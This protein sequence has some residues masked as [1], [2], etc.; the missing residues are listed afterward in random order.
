MVILTLLYS[1]TAMAQE[2]VLDEIFKSGNTTK[3]I[4][5]LLEGFDDYL[6]SLNQR[7]SFFSAGITA[8]TSLFSF[9]EKNNGLYAT[10]RKF[11]ASPFMS[12]FHRSGFGLTAST[13]IISDDK[14]F[15]PFQYAIT[16]SYDL[17][18]RKYSTGVSFTRYLVKDSLKFY[19]T[20]IQQEAFAY[21]AFKDLW[22]RPAISVAYGWGSETS[23][24]KRKLKIKKN[25]SRHSR[26]ATDV[27]LTERRDESLHDL[28]VIFSLKKDFSF[29]DVL[30][31]KDMISLTPVVLINCGT[32]QY[33]F[34]SSYSFTRT[35]SVK[36]ASLPSNVSITDRSSFSAQTAALIMRASYL[37]GRF[38]FQPQ[39]IMDY[40]IP[41]EEKQFNTA[42]SVT[43][44]VSF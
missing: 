22:I 21:F 16:P 31:N 37:S 9:E 44:G 24:E 28:S 7:R 15:Y 18:K 25:R 30:N 8:G 42:F 4:D 39:L 1:G 6:D 13:Y 14:K 26:N 34:N 2:D 11:L 43:A 23:Y 17:I 19:T 36:A 3:I 33:G 32:Q 35:S 10:E 5:S 20:P 12:Y 27:V 40:F 41:G 29:F 38:L